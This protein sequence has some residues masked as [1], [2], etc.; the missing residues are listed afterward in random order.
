MSVILSSS[1][2]GSFLRSFLP[3]SSISRLTGLME[4]MGSIATADSPGGVYCSSSVLDGSR[5]GCVGTGLRG[6]FT[7]IFI[8]RKWFGMEEQQS[9][10]RAIGDLG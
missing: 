4:D 7:R 5:N 1:R 10:R 3:R 2:D 8:A 9:V 6:V